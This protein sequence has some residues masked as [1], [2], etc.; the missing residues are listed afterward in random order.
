MPVHIFRHTIKYEMGTT[1]LCSRARTK[2]ATAPSGLSFIALRM[3]FQWVVLLVYVRLCA[4]VCGHEYSAA[5]HRHACGFQWMRAFNDAKH[6]FK[7]RSH[8]LVDSQQTQVHRS[9]PS[10]CTTLFPCRP[11]TQT[12]STSMCMFVC[13]CANVTHTHLAHFLL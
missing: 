8:E 7:Q 9:T 10:D 5:P 4:C 12:P 11:H 1:T 6:D 2:S 3:A 13:E